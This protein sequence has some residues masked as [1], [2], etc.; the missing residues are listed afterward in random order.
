MLMHHT[1]SAGISIL[2]RPDH[3]LFSIDKDLSFIRKINTGQH[4]HQRRFSAS[5]LTEQCKDLTFVNLKV[6]LVAG[7]DRIR[8]SL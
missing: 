8:S 1:D 6:Y 7:N 4:I 5:V 3:R 2:R